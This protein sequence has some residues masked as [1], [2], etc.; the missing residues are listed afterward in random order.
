M[1][2]KF[3]NLRIK[4]F[5]LLPNP[6]FLFF[7]KSHKKTV[8][9]VD[10]GIREKAGFILVTGEVGC[11][12]TT[13]IR[14]LIKGS[15]GNVI[16]SKVFNTKVTSEQLLS[17][18]NEDFGLNV[19]GKDKTMFIRDLN[20]FLIEQYSK[21]IQPILIIDEAQN[22][23]PEL[24]EEVRMLSNLETDT[25]KLLQ[26]ILVGQPELIRTLA[27]PELRQLRQRINIRCHL[28]P[29]TREEAEEYILHR[30]EIAGN[31]EAVRFEEGVA[32]AI[33]DYSR[34]IPRLINIICDFLMLS[35]FAEET[36]VLSMELVKEVI[37]ELEI[38]NRYWED[39]ARED[40]LLKLEPTSLPPGAE[41]STLM[42]KISREKF[43]Q[44]IKET[45]NR[46]DRLSEE[47]AV[48][49]ISV[50]ERAEILERCAASEEA[51]N[52]L[53]IDTYT[54]IAKL[55][56]ELEKV[57]RESEILR[58]RIGKLQREITTGQK[59]KRSLL[60]RMFS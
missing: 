39:E 37:G 25:S 5:E 60:R 8:T 6:D 10:Y 47:V 20:D 40:N 42:I 36:R 24:L 31:R 7:S 52:N 15:N 17:M 35:A 58:D 19:T 48:C 12:K 54:E 26:I 33:Y 4:P 32:H 14:N 49:H 59:A 21:N 56:S 38:E 13:L 16:L 43:M 9:F 29:L 57:G 22:L 34:G 45:G 2:E 53:M 28:F 23:S 55:S 41:Q 27:L 30:L 11:G 44:I 51:V 46:I 18:I 1:Y 3:F 50:K